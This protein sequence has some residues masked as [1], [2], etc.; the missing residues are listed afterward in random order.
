[1][2]SQRR[3]RIGAHVKVVTPDR[4][5]GLPFGLVGWVVGHSAASTHIHVQ[6]P[7]QGAKD[8]SHLAELDY[9]T[10]RTMAAREVSHALG[11][12]TPRVVSI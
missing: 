11:L 8:T 9:R 12:T 1:M 5:Q 6:F 3:P 4:A 2:P 10:V 7:S